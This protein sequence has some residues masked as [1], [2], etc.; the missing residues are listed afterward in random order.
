MRQVVLSIFIMC[1]GREASTEKCLQG[2]MHLRQAVDSE[3][4]VID[5]GCSEETKAILDK[6][7]DAVVPFTWVNDFSAARNFAL[8]QT[9]GQWVMYQDDDEWFTDTGEIEQFFLSGEY[10]NYDAA[11]YQVRDYRSYEPEDY[12]VSNAARMFRKDADTHFIN[13]VH[14]IFL[15]E[16]KKLALLK[17]YTNHYGYVY[18]S[19]RERQA[20]YERN[21][22]LL[23]QEIA[24]HPGDMSAWAHLANEYYCAEKFEELEACCLQGL[25]AAVTSTD[26]RREVALSTFVY[27]VLECALRRDEVD[28]MIARISDF[29]ASKSLASTAELRTENHSSKEQIQTKF[30]FTEWKMAGKNLAYR[31]I[32][33][34][35]VTKATLAYF[36]SLALFSTYQNEETVEACEAY[37]AIYDALAQDEQA[38]QQQFSFFSEWIF[39]DQAKQ[40]I[41]QI[42]ECAKLKEN[43]AR[44]MAQGQSTVAKPMILLLQQLY[45]E[46]DQVRNWLAT[47]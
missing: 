46:D 10:K 6:Y 35:E 20:H 16:P 9:H 19:E 44:L 34:N 27:G 31:G 28:L 39:E 33:C 4:I 36:A 24:D 42:L 5:T 37:N 11:F 41:D 2:L 26:S 17:S 3:L 22:S 25:E 45:P 40:N 13:R 12:S 7:A 23:K 43:V 32:L 47:Y 18:A 21:L 1:S 30:A 14:E 8:A 15:P 29:F 38:L